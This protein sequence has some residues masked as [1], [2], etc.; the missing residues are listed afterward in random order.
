MLAGFARLE[1]AWVGLPIYQEARCMLAQA[2]AIG[3]LEKQADTPA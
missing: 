2:A 1:N 3:R